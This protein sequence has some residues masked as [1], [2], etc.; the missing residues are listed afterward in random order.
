MREKNKNLKGFTLIEILIVIGLIAILAAITI[1]AL[2]PT[3]NFRRAR[4]SRRESEVAQLANMITQ[5]MVSPTYNGTVAGLSAPTC[6]AP[7]ANI[8]GQ[9]M[10]TLAALPVVGVQIFPAGADS[11]P[12]DPQADKQ[13]H[14]CRDATNTTFTIVAPDVDGTRISIIR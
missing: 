5:W 6:A 2:N 13:Y 3:E 8:T 7:I 10:T 12:L 4:N 1:I 14:I 11:L 9:P